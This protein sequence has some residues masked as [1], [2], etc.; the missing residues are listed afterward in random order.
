MAKGS[1]AELTTQ[2]IIS[3]E[4]GYIKADDFNYVYEE[5]MMIGKMLGKLISVR[6]ST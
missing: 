3:R 6:C 1:L 5:C 2:I 4:I